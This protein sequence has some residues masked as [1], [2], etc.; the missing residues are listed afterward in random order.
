MYKKSDILTIV[1]LSKYRYRYLLIS[2]AFTLTLLLPLALRANAISDTTPMQLIDLSVDSDTVDVSEE[3]VEINLSGE[4]FEE[5]SGFESIEFFYISPSGNQIIEGDASSDPEFIEETILIPQYAEEGL[6]RPTFTLVDVA[7]NSITLGPDDLVSLGFDAE[8]TVISDPSDTSVPVVTDVVIGSASVDTASSSASLAVNIEATDD[9]SGLDLTSSYIGFISP[10]GQR[11]GGILAAVGGNEYSSAITFA[12]YTEV[13]T[14]NMELILADYVT[15]TG[16]YDSTDLDA[17]SL[18]YSVQVTGAG[19]TTP[20]SVDLFEFST[21]D[22]LPGG[23]LG[24]PQITL[25]ADFSDNLSGFGNVTLF[26]YS[27]TTSQFVQANQYFD[28]ASY[29]YTVSFPEHAATGEWLPRVT[30]EDLAGNHEALEYLD[31]VGLGF[32]LALNFVS[33]ESDTVGV[34]G[35]VTT[36][37]EGDGA[38]VSDPFE[39]TVTSPVAGNV[40]IAQVELTNPV[41]SNDF[42]V[43][44]QQY[45]ITAPAATASDPLIFEFTID[46][47]SLLGQTD[48]TVV[49]FRNGELVEECTDVNYAIPDPCVSERATLGDGDVVITVRSTQASIWILGYETPTEPTYSFKRFKKPVKNPPKIN[50]VH[51]GQVIPVKFRLNGE[52]TRLDV[53]GA[54]VA[55]SQRINCTTLEPNTNGDGSPIRTTNNGDL[56]IKEN[57]VYKFKWKTRKKWEG[58]CRQLVLEFDNGETAIAY[59]SFDN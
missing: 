20:V 54:E 8:F 26:Y 7:S 46:S 15:N 49:V 38:T 56:K 34:G 27:Q 4:V 22:P 44:D 3:E 25:V 52:E 35:S 33:N 48:Q 40:S 47:G 32:D 41:S 59:F 42:Q 18:P 51:A 17:L 10:S 24:G 53:L 57:G 9:L 19:D 1:S 12:Q 43:F 6:W 16:F 23:D 30:S 2:L 36:D 50:H 21:A 31:L 14:W 29:Q 37:T 58:K 55:I 13:G 11:A 39:A 5:L 45:D 28:G